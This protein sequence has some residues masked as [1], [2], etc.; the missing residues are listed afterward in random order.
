MGNRLSDSYHVVTT[1]NADGA[2][3]GTV[4]AGRQVLQTVATELR[5]RRELLGWS[6]VKA[7]EQS[8]ISRTVINEIEAGRRVPSTRTYQ[9]LREAFGLSEGRHCTR[10]CRR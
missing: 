9:R 7:A 1:V 2:T 8:G 10:S 6:Q 3:D 4:E 5:R